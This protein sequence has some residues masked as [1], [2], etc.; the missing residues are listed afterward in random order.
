MRNVKYNHKTFFYT[1]FIQTKINEQIK[2][3]KAIIKIHES[4]FLPVGS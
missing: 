2:Q 1:L 3:N 4:L